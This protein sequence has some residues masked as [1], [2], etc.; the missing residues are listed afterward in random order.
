MFS[1]LC[2]IKG[3]LIM[4]ILG[5]DGYS[6]FYIH[7]NDVRDN[8]LVEFIKKSIDKVCL[9][10]I[11]EYRR[12]EV[13]LV[14]RIGRE[15]GKRYTHLC[16]YLRNGKFKNKRFL[17]VPITIIEPID[18][19]DILGIEELLFDINYPGY[20]TSK[21]IIDGFSEEE[22][23]KYEDFKIR[24]EPYKFGI[25]RKDIYPFLVNITGKVI[26]PPLVLDE[27]RKSL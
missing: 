6:R 12:K 27:E 17:G 20:P 9:E 5:L 4:Q 25:K 21:E 14:D 2:L 22:I 23:S 13:L 19:K 3:F 1:A 26:T 24:Y 15:S 18:E 10:S 16:G 7:F 11:L 8:R